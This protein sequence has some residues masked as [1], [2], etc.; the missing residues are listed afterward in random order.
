MGSAGCFSLEIP[1]VIAVRWW[2]RLES[3]ESFLVTSLALGL[4]RLEGLAPHLCLT[5][6]FPPGWVGLLHSQT[7]YVVA[8][9]P[10]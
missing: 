8:G 6:A 9:L 7:F 4:R 10:Q 1:P 3:S 5:M 2:L